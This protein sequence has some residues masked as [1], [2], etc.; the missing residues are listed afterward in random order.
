MGPS[1]LPDTHTS[2]AASSALWTTPSC[3]SWSRPSPSRLPVWGR[4][5]RPRWLQH[6]LSV[7]PESSARSGALRNVKRTHALDVQRVHHRLLRLVAGDG[8]L[9]GFLLHD[10]V[11]LL[12]L[13]LGVFVVRS[14][15]DDL[16]AER[17]HGSDEARF[18]QFESFCSFVVDAGEVLPEEL[19]GPSRRRT[20][21]A[22]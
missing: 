1:L 20:Q 14:D 17:K 3:P 5:S 12:V 21:T 6:K 16:K 15:S 22:V 18:H 11:A 13:H 9:E 2:C 4:R 7:T 10:L 19:E 8:S